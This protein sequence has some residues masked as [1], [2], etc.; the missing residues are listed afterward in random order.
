MAINIVLRV[1]NGNFSEG[2]NIDIIYDGKKESER[3]VENTNIQNLYITWQNILHSY[4]TRKISSIEVQ[5][6]HITT[7][8]WRTAKTKLQTEYEKWLKDQ[9][10]SSLIEKIISPTEQTKTSTKQNRKLVRIHLIFSPTLNQSSQ[11]DNDILRR[12]P[13][14]SYFNDHIKS[15]IA[16]NYDITFILS[17]EHTSKPIHT[18][19]FSSKPPKILAIFGGHQ[20]ELASSQSDEANKLRKICEP[21]GATVILKNVTEQQEFHQLLINDSYDILFYSGHS[22][23][24]DGGTIQFEQETSIIRDFKNDLKE[25]KKKGLKIALFNSCD[26]LKIADFLTEEVGIPAVIVMKEPVPDEFAREFFERFLCRFVQ[27]N[28]CLSIAVDLAKNDIAYR[29]NKDFPG[30]TWL[31]ITCYSNTQSEEFTWS[32]KRQIYISRQNIKIHNYFYHRQN[33][34]SQCPYQGLFHFGPQEAEFFFGREI[35]IEQ[36]YN[37]TQEAIQNAT[38]NPEK[39]NII[40]LIGASGSGKSS[41]VLAGLVPRLEKQG[42]WLF[43]YFRPGEDPFYALATA[44]VPLY[45]PELNATEKIAQETLLAKLL[46]EEDLLISK[47]FPKIQQQNPNFRVLIIADQFEEIYTLCPDEETRHKFLD[48]LLKSFTPSSQIVLLITMR[49]DFLSHALSYRPFGDIL[50]KT[51]IKILAMNEQELTEVITGPAERLGVSFEGGLAA[52]ILSDVKQQTGN[53]PLL[54]FALT[55]L[56]ESTQGVELTHKIYEEIGKVEGALSRYADDQYNQLK[57]EEKEKVQRIFIQ[58]VRPGEGAEDTRRIAMKAEIGEEN[59]SLVNKIADTRLVV[60]STN[61]SEQETV[62]VAHEALIRNWGELRNWIDSNR[63]FRAWQERLRVI[64][65]QWESTERDTELLLRGGMLVQA[66]ER[67]K[68]RPEDLIN[69]RK[70]IEESIQE[71]NRILQQE[72]ARQKREMMTAWG[73]TA[74]SIV[75][76]VVSVALGVTA[77]HQKNQAEINQAKYLGQESW[78]L[79]RQDKWSEALPIAIKAGVIV[80][81]KPGEFLYISSSL[82]R[83]LQSD[84]EYSLRSTTRSGFTSVTI[85]PDGKT[86]VSASSDKTIKIWDMATGKGKHTLTGHQESVNSVTI[87]PDGKTLVSASSDNTIKIW[88]MATGKGKHTLTGHQSSVYS[89]TISPDGKT[90]VSASDDK[91][92]KIWDMA[93]GREKHTLTG[94]QDSV[95]SVTISPDGKTLVSASLDKT[96]KIWD[97]ATGREKHTLTGHQHSVNSVTISPDGKTLVSASLDKTIKIWDMATGREKHTL[98][99]HQHSVNSVTISPDGKTLVSASLDKTIK[100]WDM[101]TGREKHTLTGHQEWVNSVT[102]SPDG[103]T[104]VSASSDNTIKIWDMATGREKHTLTGHQ[105]WVNSVTISPDGKTLVSAS[106]DK[107]IKIWDMATG[108]EKHTLTGHQDSVYSVT[109]SPDGKTLVSASLDKTIKI[110]DMATGR[111]KHTLTGHQDSVNSVTISPDGKTLVSASDDNTIKIWDMATGREKH[112]L[113][114]HQFWVNSV[115]ISPDGKTLVS[116]SDDNTIKIWDMATGREKHTLTGHQYDV[117]SVTISPDG[118]TLVSASRDKTI[119][120][121][122]MATGREKHTLTGHQDSV[123]SVTISPDG[124]T[125]V[126]ASDDN[127]IKIWDIA[128]GREKN[129]LT[130]HLSDVRSVTISPDGKTLVSASRDDTIKIWDISDINVKSLLQKVCNRVRN[131]LRHDNLVPVE[132]RYLCDQ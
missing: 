115:A 22:S 132:D 14:G 108:R 65:Q 9:K 34:E 119:K 128:R 30:A 78:S 40:P 27:E 80:R 98:T 74:G 60:T 67:L 59:W 85:S 70:F 127:T 123:N 4:T 47:V 35:F 104:L 53:L 110:W 73:I 91:T 37:A 106:S 93:T 49:A 116:A 44:L 24:K 112:T 26:G 33:D 109:I 86:L 8:K 101:A 38:P 58:L 71:K 111:E 56:W 72:K 99:G 77:V 20:G 45:T 29:E 43:T 66:E 118:K 97:M 3:I 16:D 103:K 131:Y 25:A 69:E 68:E 125:L 121:W 36:L 130:G 19:L 89:V 83:I 61:T 7:E 13:W 102:I 105:E 79:L 48:C 12:L 82:Q 11:R 96:I 18:N 87:S 122:D 100:I 6:T 129:T 57:P 23:S 63:E 124:K 2:F 117:R 41:L 5:D 15:D 81:D 107:T 42:N 39:R 64:R 54:E 28:N 55:K 120:I 32:K 52:T 95:Y 46:K 75:A 31:P 126:S 62:E 94:H 90:L 92:I 21:N 10:I 114:G 84:F 1:L 51:D 17:K 113:T 50:Q 88:D 76:V